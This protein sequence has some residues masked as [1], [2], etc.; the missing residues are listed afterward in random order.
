MLPSDAYFLLVCL[1]VIT[2]LLAMLHRH[3]GRKLLRKDW[4]RGMIYLFVA[5][6]PKGWT[7]DMDLQTLAT[8]TLF[9][10]LGIRYEKQTAHVAGTWNAHYRL[11][12]VE[13]QGMQIY[14][15][16]EICHLVCNE[17]KDNIQIPFFTTCLT[18]ED[19]KA[20]VTKK[21]VTSMILC[22]TTQYVK[23]YYWMID[24][25]AAYITKG[26]YGWNKISILRWFASF[27]GR[28]QELAACNEGGVDRIA[29]PIGFQ[30]RVREHLQAIDSIIPKNNLLVDGSRIGPNDCVIYAAL[31]IFLDNPL[32]VKFASQHEFKSSHSYI[33]R[34]ERVLAGGSDSDI[35]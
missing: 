31:K 3:S 9:D 13:Y 35:E 26:I 16:S 11:P 29:S 6:R 23:R 24:D 34:V 17:F 8:V 4:E 7:F 33:T 1:V 32:P 27:N 2:Q 22:G 5:E 18:G 15:F 19:T 28:R 20:T 25:N 12:V 10:A 30:S 14:D 21:A